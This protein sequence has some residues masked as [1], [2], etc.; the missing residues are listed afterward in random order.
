MTHKDVNSTLNLDSGNKN[1]TVFIGNL[2]SI[3]SLW[4]SSSFYGAL[5]WQ[6]GL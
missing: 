6:F 3:V 5:L 4:C 1:R 2:C